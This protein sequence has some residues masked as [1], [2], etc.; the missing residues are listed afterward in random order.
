MVAE[1]ILKATNAVP[2]LQGDSRE[3]TMRMVKVRPIAIGLGLIGVVAAI[4]C[5]GE[6][7]G[8]GHAKSA[9]IPSMPAYPDPKAEKKSEPTAAEPAKSKDP[10]QICAGAADVK[11]ARSD[12]APSAAGAKV[13]LADKDRVQGDLGPSFKGAKEGTHSMADLQA[14]EK[15]SAWE[16]LLGHAEDVPPAQ[17][18]ATWDKL[19]ERAAVGYMQS[20]TT[21]TAAYEGVFTS[22]SLVKRYPHLAKSQE[23]MAKRGEAG[24]A[25][26]E[27]CLQHAYRGQHCIDMMTEFL[28][29]SNTSPDV[30]FAF[31]KIAR[32]NQNHYVAVPFF[33]WALDQKKD[34]KESTST[35]TAAQ[36][37][38]DE[39]LK[40]AVVAG[41]GLPPDYPNAGGA[42]QI[43]ANSC[44][45]NLKAEIKKELVEN[46]S[47]YYRDNACAVI[48]AKGDL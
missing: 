4:G 9:S 27:T 47:G 8:S 12:D 25:A 3:E 22:Q 45:D 33:K 36:M 28:K 40:L 48:K 14:L 30:G 44:Y 13:W 17:R 19:V 24:K 34:A 35:T 10:K 16:E 11:I 20:L 41:L 1:R 37:C 15:R 43:A 6:N 23:F 38:G 46:G 7:A 18:N 31:G 26:S 32:K 5:G 42:R 21:N 39:D 29:T 2:I